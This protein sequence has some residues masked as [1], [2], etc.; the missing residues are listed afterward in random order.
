MNEPVNPKPEADSLVA[1]QSRPGPQSNAESG[2]APASEGPVPLREGAPLTARD[3]LPTLENRVCAHGAGEKI[4]PSAFEFFN[5]YMGGWRAGLHLLAGE[6]GSGK[7]SFAL[8]NA[9]AAARQGFPALP[10]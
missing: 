3:Y 2:S 4:I 5:Q 6:P 10:C 8:C 1:V 7:T 9:A